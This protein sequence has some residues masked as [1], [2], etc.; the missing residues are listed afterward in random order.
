MIGGPEI[1]VIA[2]VALILFGPDKI[3]QMLQT[4]KKAVGLYV[5]ARDQVQEVVSTQ[6]ISPEEIEMLKDPLGLK[7]DLKS[8]APVNKGSLLTPER[9]SLYNQTMT[10]PPVAVAP[11]APA[12][13][14]SPVA[15]AASEVTS[16]VASANEAVTAQQ[17]QVQAE[18]TIPAAA[19]GAAAVADRATAVVAT[20]NPT[21]APTAAGSIWASLEQTSTATAEEVAQSKE[22]A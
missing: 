17:P 10:A 2:I 18:V 6:I 19:G 1:V 14:M 20:P 5:E 21:V 11:A 3:P 12:A 13:E 7:G 9:Q 4:V 8:G 15:D 22:G 16:E